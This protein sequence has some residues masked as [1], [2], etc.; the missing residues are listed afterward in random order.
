MSSETQSKQQPMAVALLWSGLTT[1]SIYVRW[2]L[3]VFMMS[4]ALMVIRTIF[5]LSPKQKKDFAEVM[6]EVAHLN[7]S[8]L[9]V[10]DW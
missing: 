8:K 4:N 2:T 1:L 7:V 3:R 10:D 6:N 5:W 9:N